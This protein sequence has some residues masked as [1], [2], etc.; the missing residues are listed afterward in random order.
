MSDSLRTI[1]HLKFPLTSSLISQSLTTFVLQVFGFDDR[2]FI[3]LTT[4]VYC[5]NAAMSSS[6]VLCSE[7][8][9]SSLSTP[10]PFP[11]ISLPTS[12]YTRVVSGV[13]H[14]GLLSVVLLLH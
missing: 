5:T 4:A 2:S 11:L 12:Y 13:A 14:L 8:S 3:S 7:P 9:Y 1:D 10:K 6:S